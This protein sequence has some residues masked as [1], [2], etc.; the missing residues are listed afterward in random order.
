MA[1]TMASTPSACTEVTRKNAEPVS[2][3][4]RCFLALSRRLRFVAQCTAAL[5][6][7]V[8]WSP[9][10]HH[11]LRGLEAAEERIENDLLAILGARPQSPVDL[12]L[13]GL[14]WKL[15][16]A[17]AL[18]DGEDSRFYLDRLLAWPD[19]LYLA[20]DVAGAERLNISI[21]FCLAALSDLSDRDAPSLPMARRFPGPF[22][23]GPGAP[24]V[25][26]C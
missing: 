7:E 16:M 19:L 13:Q 9:A 14:A 15:H 4:G 25:M 23:P 17:R 21:R 1:E 12:H 5:D 20:E 18:E 3:V 11:H 8:P 22:E 2:P 26:V 6:R 24:A 10:F